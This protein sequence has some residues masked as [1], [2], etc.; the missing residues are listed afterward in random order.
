[1]AYICTRPFRESRA[2]DELVVLEVL[3][4]DRDALLDRRLGGLDVQFGPFRS[5]VRRSD[6]SELCV[7]ND[8]TVSFSKSARARG[9]VVTATHP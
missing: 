9:M 3:D 2:L 1:M 4:D 8:E 6:T 7:A 5:L